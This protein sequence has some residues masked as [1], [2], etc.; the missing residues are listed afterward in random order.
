MS[1]CYQ[2]LQ[3]LIRSVTET[4]GFKGAIY[5]DPNRELYRALG[6]TL[7]TLAQTPVGQERRSYLTLSPLSNALRSIWV[8]SLASSLV[9]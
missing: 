8:C 9:K 3:L 1:I 2:R 5:A 6:M 4:T 7:E